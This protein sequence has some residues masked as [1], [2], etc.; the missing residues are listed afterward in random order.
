MSQEEK[1]ACYT[2]VMSQFH[3]KYREQM[4]ARF[5]RNFEMK[6]PK[7]YI[8]DDIFVIKDDACPGA[9]FPL[10]EVFEGRDREAFGFFGT[11]YVIS[12]RDDRHLS[13]LDGYVKA[14]DGVEFKM[15]ANRPCRGI[16]GKL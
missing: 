6:W 4:W 10:S 2:N 8:P 15:T 9:N 1:N 11:K 14:C 5:T 3:E 16:P 7:T 12:P 13:T